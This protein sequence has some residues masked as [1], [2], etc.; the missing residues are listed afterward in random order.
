VRS[1]GT[2]FTRSPDAAEFS[3]AWIDGD[4][5][6]R[7]RSAPGHGAAVGAAASGSS[8]LEIEPD[9]RLPRHSDSAEETIVVVAGA[10][11]V[12]VGEES[13]GVAQGGIALVPAGASHEVRNA[14]KD[15]LRFLAVYAAAEVTT[16]YN[17]PVQPEGKRERNPLP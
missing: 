2:P 4:E 5:A 9:C 14:G 3:Q 15:P 12:T 6:S 13:A 7:W 11:E 16:T 1:D 17:E 10:A 8:I